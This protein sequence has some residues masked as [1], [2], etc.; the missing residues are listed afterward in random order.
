MRGLAQ[1]HDVS[2]LSLRCDD[3]YGAHA[4]EV[5]RSYCKNVVSVVH[6]VLDVPIT[7]KR[8]M[9][10][11]SMAS[12]HSFDHM[13]VRR[14]DFQAELR[15]MLESG[16]YD[17]VQVEFAQMASYD[18]DSRARR[19]PLLVLDEHNIEYDLVRRSAEAPS[20]L[21]RKLYNEVNWRKLRREEREAWR[22]FDGI[23]L[24]SKRDERM[25]R[26]D[27]PGAR[28]SVV[29]NAVDLEH[30][31]PSHAPIEAGNLLFFGA[32]NYY[33]NTD[34]ILHFVAETFPKIRMRQPTA[35]LVVVGPNPPESV[36]ACRNDAVEV[37]GLVDDPRVFLDRAEV[38]VVPLRIGGGT[39]F[40][41][42][43]AMAKGKAIVSTRI[44]AE[45][46]DVEHERHLLLADEPEDFAH[47]V[48]R[49][50]S[51]PKLRER[52]GRAARQLA[53]ER[54]GWQRAVRELERFY[55]RLSD[56]GPR[57]KS[58]DRPHRV[59]VAGAPEKRH[60]DV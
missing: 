56:A 51:E 3:A 9:Q 48:E 25:L 35:K 57:A 1:H 5:T 44:G 32:I 7:E 28:T 37:T 20:G 52:L 15:S 46:L 14:D 22:R 10:L 49:V 19:A 45:G 47:Q 53:E 16:K 58:A 24:T 12:R 50:L 39:R 27:E 21:P 26:E 60:V 31:A 36:L 11:R 23:V 42:V 38:V 34:G 40:K 17:L 55:E 13:L 29:P 2:L 6:D 30:F 8:L 41:I 33:P 18:Y 4:L 59:E 54:F 43:E